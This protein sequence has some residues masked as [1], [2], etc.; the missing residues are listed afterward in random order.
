MGT[1]V[2]RIIGTPPPPWLLIFEKFPNPSI[3]FRFYF[4][5]KR[6]KSKRYL[7]CEI[8]TCEKVQCMSILRRW[9]EM[10]RLQFFNSQYHGLKLPKWVSVSLRDRSETHFCLRDRSEDFFSPLPPLLLIFGKV[11]NL[12]TPQRPWLFGTLE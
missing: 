1:L 3:I 4:K 9:S 6:T 12:P 2:Y 5:T 8:K 7:L 11:S 10:Q